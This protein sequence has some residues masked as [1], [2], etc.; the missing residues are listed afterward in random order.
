MS[1]RVREAETK[2]GLRAQRPAPQEPQRVVG[3]L[4]KPRRSGTPPAT[5]NQTFQ[6]RD[7]QSR[8]DFQSA[9]RGIAVLL[10]SA[11]LLTACAQKPALPNYGA[12]PDFQLTDQTGAQFSSAALK[13]KVW[14]ADFI[15][16]NCPGPCPMMSSKMN[17][18]QKEIGRAHV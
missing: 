18:I 6:M 2:L 13:G 1:F 4:G 11:L 15:F 7:Y 5:V 8:A 9:P 17:Q 3:R 12:I 14:V 16:T 10:A